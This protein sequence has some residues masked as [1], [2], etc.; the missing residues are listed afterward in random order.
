MLLTIH[1]AAERLRVSPRTV[2]REILAGKLAVVRVR[3][4][5]RIR[6]EELQRYVR[7]GECQSVESANAGRDG[8]W[9]EMSGSAANGE[10]AG[11][12]TSSPKP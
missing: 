4:R 10:R 8:G 5:V 9:P 1:E 2:E 3:S 11:Q 12:A 6:E 7:E